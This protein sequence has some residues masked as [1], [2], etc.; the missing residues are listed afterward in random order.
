VRLIFWFV[1]FACSGLAC[2][3]TPVVLR[4]LFWKRTTRAG[5]IAGMI[6]GFLTASLWVIAFKSRALD[7]YEMIPGFPAAFLV[8]IA[9]SLVTEP[10]AGAVEEFEDVQRN[11]SG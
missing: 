9:V 7:L 11:V 2:A 1:L 8:T 10:P 6:T 4:S 5:A 3:F